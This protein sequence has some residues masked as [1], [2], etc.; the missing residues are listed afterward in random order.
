MYIWGS[1]EAGNP[2]NLCKKTENFLVKVK[3]SV[4]FTD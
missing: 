3:M 1:D 2:K 4:V